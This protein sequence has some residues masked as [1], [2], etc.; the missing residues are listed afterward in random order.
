MSSNGTQVFVLYPRQEGVT[1][2][3]KYYLETHM[4]LCAK[5]WGPHG[6][7]SWSVTKLSDDSPYIISTTIVFESAEA[8]GKA[9][10][11]PG[12]AEI[13]GDVP[14][15]TNVQPTLIQGG[16]IAKSTL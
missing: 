8:F 6:L 15:F 16:I 5:H 14:K 3:E 10:T 13:Q 4:P 9:I 12:T 1:F 7:K 2:D 11:D